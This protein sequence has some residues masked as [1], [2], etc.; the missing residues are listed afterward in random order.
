MHNFQIKLVFKVMLI[1]LIAILLFNKINFSDLKSTLG[2]IELSIFIVPGFLLFFI[3]IVQGIRW[4]LIGNKLGF[5]WKLRKVV[6]LSL[7]GNFFNQFLPGSSG[8]DAVRIFKVNRAKIPLRLAVSS[9]IADRLSALFAICLIFLFGL[10]K[11]KNLLFF[12]FTPQIL[13][14]ICLIFKNPQ[15]WTL[16]SPAQTKMRRQRRWRILRR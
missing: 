12:Y 6:E 1:F 15:K 4:W 2:K 11:L 14:L 13:N 3:L 10:F 5:A 8:G 7:I 9:V 16:K